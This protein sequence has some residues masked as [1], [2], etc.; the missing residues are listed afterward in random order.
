M[1]LIYIF[2]I[3]ILFI[4]VVFAFP[5][6]NILFAVASNILFFRND[7]YGNTMFNN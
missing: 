6:A 1:K 5:I 7:F 2:A 3:I 4:L